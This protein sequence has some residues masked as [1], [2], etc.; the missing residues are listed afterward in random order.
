MKKKNKLNGLMSFNVILIFLVLAVF[1][2]SGQQG[3]SQSGTTPG[4]TTTTS[5]ARYGLDFNFVEGIDYLSQGDKIKAGDLIFVKLLLENNGEIPKSGQVCIRDNL[6]D[7]YGGISKSC[8]S[9]RVNG[10]VYEA[11]KL[12]KIGKTEVLFGEYKYEDFPI[13]QDVTVFVNTKY[14][15][16]LITDSVVSVPEPQTE[17]LKVTD[18][19]S[20][21]SISIEKRVALKTGGYGVDLSI[22][23]SKKD[24][25]IK[26]TTPDYR[27]EGLIFDPQLS[28]VSLICGY[29]DKSIKFVEFKDGE[30]KSLIKCEALLPSQESVNYPLLLSIHYGAEREKKFTF[31]LEKEVST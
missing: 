15:E 9:F 26:I 4:K 18:K 3:C 2:V 29:D 14:A 31:T 13:T 11:E 24:R 17:R 10:A 12:I 30:S 23:I 22:T 5:A 16:Q 20:P 8:K 19:P 6:E 21:I 1:L 27:R 7:V 28:S 25:E